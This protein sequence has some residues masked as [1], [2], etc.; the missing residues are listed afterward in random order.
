MNMKVAW[1]PC[2]NYYLRRPTD[3]DD[4]ILV[5]VFDSMYG[6]SKNPEKRDWY[7]ESYHAY[8]ESVNL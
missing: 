8:C 4:A 5:A 7:T 1:Q 3:I 6:K 2:I